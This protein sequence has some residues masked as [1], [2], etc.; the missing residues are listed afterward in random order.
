MGTLIFLLI[1]FFVLLPLWRIAWAVWRQYRLVRRH[2]RQAEAFRDAFARGASG[3]G[4]ES[5]A[6]ESPK[7]KKIARD[8]GEYVAFEEMRVYTEPSGNEPSGA[9]Q[10]APKP[11]AQVEDA[12]WEEIK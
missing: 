9:S 1:F 10:R 2:M 8:V 6:P 3:P 12:D 5:A 4:R 11:E 7:K